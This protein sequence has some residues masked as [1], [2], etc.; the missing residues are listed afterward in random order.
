MKQAQIFNVP[1]NSFILLSADLIINCGGYIIGL[2]QY[3]DRL[4]SSRGMIC[5]EVG[6]KKN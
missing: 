3:Q 1:S 6:I 5:V 2:E 4:E